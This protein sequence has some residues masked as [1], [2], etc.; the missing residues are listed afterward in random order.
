MNNADEKVLRQTAEAIGSYSHA[1]LL[2]EWLRENDLIKSDISVTDLAYDYAI[3]YES[4]K[5][6]GNLSFLPSYSRLK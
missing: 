6:R 1:L 2:I 3:R 4:D 5:V